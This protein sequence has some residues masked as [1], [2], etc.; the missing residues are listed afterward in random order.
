MEGE[1][2]LGCLP[3]VEVRSEEEDPT[4]SIQ[5]VN[6]VQLTID[7]RTITIPDSSS[8]TVTEPTLLFSAMTGCCMGEVYEF[9]T[10]L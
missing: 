3:A 1:L 9:A 6:T 2:W 4:C 7:H 5:L 8:K 10:I